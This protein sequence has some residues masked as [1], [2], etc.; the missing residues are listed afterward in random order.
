MEPDSK[1]RC[2]S[3]MLF[4]ST[5][6]GVALPVLI[7]SPDASERYS[8]SSSSGLFFLSQNGFAKVNTSV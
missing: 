2:K 8:Y 5:P 1:E 7:S 3:S 4:S 6:F